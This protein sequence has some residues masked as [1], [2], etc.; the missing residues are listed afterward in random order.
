M[1]VGGATLA[2]AAAGIGMFV[3]LGASL[4]LPVARPD[5]PI[6]YLFIGASPLLFA[7]V[8]LI[9]GLL[10][11][12]AHVQLFSEA[13][14][15]WSWRATGYLLPIALLGSSLLS[16]LVLLPEAGDRLS[17]LVYV[18]DDMRPWWAAALSA[19]AIVRLDRQRG[20]PWRGGVIAAAGRLTAPAR[21]FALEATLFL[22][23][24]ACAIVSSPHVRF[25]FVLH[26]DEP[27]YL[28]LCENFYQGRGLH[29][30]GQQT[31]EEL[32]LAYQPPVWRNVA[33]FAEGVKQDVRH[34]QEDARIFFTSGLS[35]RYN[36]AR[37]VE[38]WFLEGRNGGFYQVHNPGLSVV[39]FP[40]Y[41]LDRHFFSTSAAYQD[42]F[43]AQLPMTNLACLLLFAWLGVAVF[44]LIVASTG[45][46]LLAWLLAATAMLTMPLAAF[47]F[48][49]YP[50][51]TGG[52]IVAVVSRWLL[53]RDEHTR[54]SAVA[55]AVLAAFLPW[56]HVRFLLL[57]AVLGV[58]GFARL[59][60][61][62]IA[63]TTAYAVMI[64]GLCLYAYHLT[65]SM[66]PDAMYQGE[67]SSSPWRLRDAMQ[68]VISFPL[69][70]IWGFL[71]HAP[72][73][74]VAIPGWAVLAR[75]Q[76]RA[77][78]L[79]ALLIASLVIPSSGHGFTAAGATPLR[80]LVA[81]IPLAMVPLAWTLIRWGHRAWVRVAFAILLV[82]SLDAAFSYTF[83]HRKEVG[84]MVD[85]A[86]SG[87]TPNLLFPWTH[88]IP[89]QHWPGTFALF[90]MW[91]VLCA[92]LL[93]V[94]FAFVRRCIDRAPA[95]VR[96]RH[97]IGGVLVFMALASGAAA[98]GG[99]W[100]RMDYF[101]PIQQ[102]RTA[103]I[104]RVLPM[105]RCRICYS[106]LRGEFGRGNVLADSPVTF[107]FAALRAG[108]RLGDPAAFRATATV[109][110][111]AGWGTLAVDFGDDAVERVELLGSVDLHHAYASAGERRVTARFTP[112]GGTFE[113][114]TATVT[115]H[116]SA[117]DPERVRGMPLA[118]LRVP[119]RFTIERILVG[120]DSVR[121]QTSDRSGR[122]L[123]SLDAALVP[124]GVP[125]AWVLVWDGTYW[126]AQPWDAG[127]SIAAASWVAVV[128]VDAGG[129]SRAEPVFLEWPPAAA[130]IGSP[131]VV[132]P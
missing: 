89:W 74:V 90:V 18:F 100:T 25:T 118:L 101:V 1:N 82:V 28:R 77:A 87:W 38:G 131:A 129:S 29:V 44:R 11:W 63:F 20:S 84:R 5:H 88:G 47:A 42:V 113:Q 105:D 128:A 91:A 60:G 92:A 14:D 58:W 108:V 4:L 117:I 22:L 132:F 3:W 73:Y 27:K 124:G 115:A 26:G 76:P 71:P 56:L 31:L 99:E 69:D 24:I 68:A 81:S 6:E 106:S 57:S 86:V 85:W 79:L 59:R 19:T 15:R 93:L 49:I 83:H 96:L 21:T 114:R 17:V 65:G 123:M 2:A 41:F 23:L 33:L 46:P 72:V 50:E 40:A 102:A 7:A 36:R 112:H 52:I 16:A 64:I 130:I 32:S 111:G 8:T 43:P 116:P 110:E 53:F 37:F 39:L 127:L 51:V 10:L 55:T 104:D 80:H 54:R 35:F 109:P 66:R 120:A 126:H 119:V 61:R 125:Q 48:Q 94:P 98:L 70:R 30:A 78:A 9:A 103:V 107:T 12:L 34:L 97:A 62:R 13:A 67:G 75:V 121:V 122:D 95:T 45:R